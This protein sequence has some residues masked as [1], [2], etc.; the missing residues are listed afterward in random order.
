[1]NVNIGAVSTRFVVLGGSDF[2]NQNVAKVAR[3]IHEFLER[4][5]DAKFASNVTVRTGSKSVVTNNKS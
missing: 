4:T 3:K 1:M 5:N 2:E